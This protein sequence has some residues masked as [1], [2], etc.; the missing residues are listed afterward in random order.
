[1]RYAPQ[2][3]GVRAI[4]VALTISNHIGPT[5]WYVNGTLGVDVFF[6]LS[7]FLIT[8]LLIGEDRT[9]GRICLKC[10]YARRFFRIAPLYY[11]TIALYAITSYVLFARGIDLTRLSQMRAAAPAVL[12]FMGEYR[13]EAAGTLLGHTWTLGIEEK[14]YIL[15]PLLFVAMRQLR[16]ALL[17]SLL[18]AVTLGCWLFLVQEGARGYGGI[19]IGS[20]LAVVYAQNS[21]KARRTIVSIPTWVFASVLVLCYLATLATHNSLAS[22]FA[23][24][25]VSGL[26]IVSLV[27]RRGVLCRVLSSAPF[28]FVGKRTYGI[29]LLHVLVANAVTTVLAHRHLDLAWPIRG[30]LAFAGAVLVASIAK[31]VLEDPMIDVGKR[32]SR[33]LLGPPRVSDVAHSEHP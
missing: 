2:L 23:L 13:P 1:M 3:D 5:A 31:F 15:W 10:F 16:Y 21:S 26:L 24:T 28:V 8:T 7:G 18:A 19:A 4:C 9:T 14:Y 33:R 30:A 22:H 32:I 11:L 20:L 27:E 25:G 29:Y 6:A 17:V 12:V